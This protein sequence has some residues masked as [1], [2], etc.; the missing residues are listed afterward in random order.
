MAA[1]PANTGKGRVRGSGE[2]G[3][4]QISSNAKKHAGKWRASVEA[5]Y[6]R[7]GKRIRKEVIAPTK[8]ELMVKI[9]L[10]KERSKEEAVPEMTVNGDSTVAEYLDDWLASPQVADVRPGTRALYESNCR[11]YLKPELGR[12]KLRDLTPAHVDRMLTN[13]DKPGY[14]TVKKEGKTGVRHAEDR[15]SR[16][17]QQ[18]IRS[19]L[20]NA[21]NRA[22][23]YE[24]VPRNVAAKTRSPRNDAKQVEAFTTDEVRSLLAAA[25]D[26]RIGRVLQ[27][28]VFTGLRKGE[29]GALTWSDIDF[30]SSQLQV[31]GTLTRHGGSLQVGKPKTKD[32]ARTIVLSPPAV[33]ALKA[34]KAAQKL[35]RM[36]C[37]PGLRKEQAFVFTTLMGGPLD[38][39]SMLRDFWNLCD[40]AEVPRRG[41]HSLRHTFATLGLENGAPLTVI[42]KT[43]GH[44]NINITGTLYAHVTAKSQAEAVNAVAAAIGGA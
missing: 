18:I 37:P 12:I 40:E 42:S 35:D 30:I 2:G 29:I 26:S 28:A 39:R 36:A 6:G 1:K 32:S 4:W 7:N 31:N 25:G 14:V 11:L 19:T 17:T 5:G 13:L 38:G 3:I 16:R 15:L 34:Q 10:A 9:E 27:L 8:K 23:K 22:E 43:L 20:V 41:L 21:L 24:L 44:T 33:A